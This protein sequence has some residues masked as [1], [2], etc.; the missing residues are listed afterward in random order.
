M[1]LGGPI[2]SNFAHYFPNRI[3]RLVLLCPA[4]GLPRTQLPLARRIILSNLIPQPLL[5]KLVYVLPIRPIGDLGNWQ[6]N[7]HKGFMHSFT[8]SWLSVVMGPGSALAL[9]STDPR[10]L[11]GHSRACVRAL[12]STTPR[13]TRRWSSRLARACALSGATTTRL[14]PCRRAS[15]CCFPLWHMHT[16]LCTDTGPLSSD[17]LWRPGRPRGPRWWTLDHPHPPRGGGQAH[18]R[19]S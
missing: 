12:F 13:C 1:S 9:H 14:C 17:R 6:V 15:V 11:L 19:V 5:N 3:D 16:N 18:A 8:V 10:T 7:K 2:V 4:G